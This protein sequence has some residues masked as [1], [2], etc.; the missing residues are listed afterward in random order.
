MQ[1]A[2]KK[3]SDQRA[4]RIIDEAHAQV[5]ELL[6][7]AEQEVRSLKSSAQKAGL[8]QGHAQAEQLLLKLGVLE[9]SMK[10]EM[11]ADV[12]H[13][14]FEVAEGL[15]DLELAKNPE[16][17]LQ[18]TIAVLKTLPDAK[19]V[20]LR[21]SPKNAAILRENKQKLIDALERA[22]DVDIRVDKQVR[23]GVLVQTESGVVDAQVS[24]QLEEIARALGW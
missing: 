21:A 18:I 7:A 11:A 9:N 14:A 22:K 24:T 15:V 1:N 10:D 20:Y 3:D 8:K 13:A 16:R 2:D 19:Q 5:S 4:Q 23:R 6:L 17:V 12:A